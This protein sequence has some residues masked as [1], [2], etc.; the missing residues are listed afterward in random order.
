[1]KLAKKIISVMA[2]GAAMMSMGMTALAAPVS[3]ATIDTARTAS[4]TVYKYDITAAEKD[5][6]WNQ[7][8]YKSTGVY[9]QTVNDTL[10]SSSKE[11]KLPNGD[12]SYGYAVKGVEFTYL[13]VA[14]ISTY[15]KS[16]IGLVYG[17]EA[18]GSGE[19]MLSAIG[20]SWDNRLKA[21]DKTVGGKKMYYFESDT[22]INA[23]SSA[24]AANATTVKDALEAYVAAGGGTAM[25]QT[26]SYGKTSAKDLPLG[27]YLMVETKVP[28][29][30][31]TTTT[32]FFV[33]LP[34]TSINGTNATD[35][36]TRWMYDVTVYPKNQ[37]GMPTLEKTVREA[38]QDTGK[39]NGTT[40]DITDG[41]AH[42]ATG[43]DGDVMDYQIIS[44]LPAITSTASYLTTY[45][46]VDTLS[47]GLSYNKNDVTVEFFTDA[48]CT[49]KITTWKQTDADPKF[50]VAYGTADDNATTMTVS[51]TAAGLAEINS[52]NTVYTTAGAVDRGYSSCTMR[53]TYAATLHSDATVVYGDNGNPNEVVL[54][55][56]RT[57]TDYFDTLKDCCHVFTYA[58]D[59]TK[60]F[61]DDR[62]DFSKVNMLV[63][64]QTDG[65]YVTATLI[66]GIYYVTGHQTAEADA[67]VFVPTATGKIVI[68]GLEDDTY[69]ITE[70]ATSDGYSLLK[71]AIEV[72]IKSAAS[73][74]I[75]PVC[76]AALLTATAT[77]NGDA[78][79]MAA[80]NGSVNAVVEL[81][82][83]NNRVPTVP[84]T[85]ENGFALWVAGG[86]MLAAASMLVLILNRKKHSED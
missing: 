53:I 54:T 77:I 49:D 28:E 69:V 75:C 82:V 22:L 14:D 16:K 60:Q 13:R 47:K 56:K 61:S 5:G 85:G 32:P 78:A 76:E 11:N 42:T 38:K 21:A 33:S 27:L 50:A 86:L 37:S 4:L 45:T 72:E 52:A 80:D 44:T 64:N 2:A 25:T 48:A 63:Y 6:V 23:L 46:Y 62:G 31:T 79:A 67:T 59:L 3:E 19:Q 12:T 73:A 43:S 35:G 68:K 29:Y 40:N 1:M 26:D 20:L 36:G 30:I 24:V 70:T 74:N 10:G 8:D 34:M 9:D 7:N 15:S 83:I 57:S 55:W 39:H 71:N 51:M 18:D 41:Y 66:D 65:Y 81:T 58:L 84:L 17:F